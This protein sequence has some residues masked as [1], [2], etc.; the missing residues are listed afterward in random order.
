VD[1]AYF[2][3]LARYN[4]WANR[5]LYDACGALSRDDYVAPRPSFFGSIH[6]T[7]NHILVGDRVWM[8]R[9]E[10]TPLGIS[11]LD[12]VLYDDFAALRAARAAE[13]ERIQRWTQRLGDEAL[14]GDLE[15]RNMA[16]EAKRSPLR[17]AIAHFF[18][19]QTHHRGQAHGLL[20]ATP[21]APP[22][23]DLLYFLPEDR[24]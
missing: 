9:F 20:S 2:Q 7:L 10:A 3:R 5:R 16:G 13:D 6:R 19:H 24:G 23:L 8:S 15:Y 17:W 4:A 18:N 22:P 21:V 11:S 1:S 14:G 12:Q